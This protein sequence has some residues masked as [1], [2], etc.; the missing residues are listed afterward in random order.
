MNPIIPH[1]VSECLEDLQVKET[2]N[3]PKTKPFKLLIKKINFI[4]QINGKK[5]GIIVTKNN[6]SEDRIV[7]FSYFE[8]RKN[9]KN[10]SYFLKQLI[11]NSLYDI[12]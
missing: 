12:S 2:L 11:T 5:R 7:L 6:I 4:V 3:W 10:L 9:R 1:F 8:I